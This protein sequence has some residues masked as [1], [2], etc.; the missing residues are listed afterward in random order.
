MSPGHEI[1][2]SASP[3]R[4]GFFQVE[5]DEIRLPNGRVTK[6]EYVLHPGAAA[7]VPLRG[8]PQDGQEVLLVRQNRHAVGDDLLEIP[9]GKLDVDG[10][11][12]EQC[13][14]REL[15]EETGFRA[16]RLVAL[17]RFFSSPGFTDEAFHLFLATDLE[18]VAPP[19]EDDDGEPIAAAWLDLDDAVAALGD[20]RIVDAKSAIGIA[21][22]R[23]RQAGQEHTAP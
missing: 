2:S 20:G 9:A 6:R 18:P 7:V 12:P 4:G 19:P 3:F 23:L 8:R 1:V 16:G 13:A 14:S 5:V 15:I 11:T 22:A 17:G 10:E 21:L